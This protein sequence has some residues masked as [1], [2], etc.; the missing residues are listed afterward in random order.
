MQW[1]GA[2]NLMIRLWFAYTVIQW[3]FEL[4][5]D[6][7]GGR[8]SDEEQMQRRRNLPDSIFN[9]I[10]MYEQEMQRPEYRHRHH[11]PVVGEVVDN[12]VEIMGLPPDQE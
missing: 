5:E 7:T 3:Y 6:E 1:N 9:Q 11:G 12:Q 10:M 4:K 2:L 8:V